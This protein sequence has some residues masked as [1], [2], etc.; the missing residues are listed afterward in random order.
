MIQF[1]PRLSKT[2]GAVSIRKLM[3]AKF[4]RLGGLLATGFWESELLAYTSPQSRHFDKVNG[5]QPEEA[6]LSVGNSI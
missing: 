6:W 5:P 2:S 3:S 1:T 4:N